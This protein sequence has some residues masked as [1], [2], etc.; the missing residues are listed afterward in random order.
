MLK[1]YLIENLLNI[2]YKKGFTL[3]AFFLSQFVDNRKSAFPLAVRLFHVTLFCL[4]YPLPPGEGNE[5]SHPEQAAKSV[6]T[7][8]KRD[9][10][11]L[12][13]VSGSRCIKSP[14]PPFTKGGNV[15]ASLLKGIVNISLQ[16]K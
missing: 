13:G 16:I 15:A 6:K 9:F 1:C 5:S 14:P 7:K 3:A 2:N 10:K 4:H 11:P 12:P 8:S